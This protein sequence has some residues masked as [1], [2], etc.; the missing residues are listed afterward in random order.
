MRRS[1]RATWGMG[2]CILGLL[3]VVAWCLDV[4]IPLVGAEYAPFAD[5]VPM[6]KLGQMQFHRG[7][8]TTYKRSSPIPQLRCVKGC[9]FEPGRPCH[10]VP[11][12]SS[13]PD[14]VMV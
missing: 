13:F 9:E 8:D 11:F 12:L 2:R 5:S 10:P 4:A 1:R 6:S 7:Q 3:V 14:V